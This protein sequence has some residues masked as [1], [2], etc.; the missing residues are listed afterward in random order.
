MKRIAAPMIGGVVTSAVLELLLYPVIYSLWR[1]R[2]LAPAPAVG[3]APEPAPGTAAARPRR[4]LLPAALVALA[5]GAGIWGYQAWRTPP[6]AAGGAASAPAGI[7]FDTR[8]VNAM[9]VQFYHPKG[10]LNVDDNEVLVQ[11]TDSASGKPVDVGAVR[12]DLD[13]DMPGMAMHSGSTVTAEGTPGRYRVR[14][15][16]DMAGDWTAQLH[17]D[18]PRGPGS[19]SFTVN[20]GP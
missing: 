10:R 7:L 19:L 12:F 13:M 17:Y 5:V 11:F 4:S 18:G 2:H 3:G 20:V 1:R 9:T 15:H 6:A 14:V 16:A 8:T